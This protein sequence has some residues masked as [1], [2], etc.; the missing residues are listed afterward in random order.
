MNT[1]DLTSLHWS[2]LFF[3]NLE[4]YS[5]F[6]VFLNW[7]LWN[8]YI[9]MTRVFQFWFFFL[10]WKSAVFYFPKSRPWFSMYIHELVLSS[11]FVI[12]VWSPVVCLC[13]LSPLLLYGFK[14]LEGGAM[15]MFKQRF[16]N[17]ITLTFFSGQWSMGHCFY[18]FRNL[19]GLIYFIVL[20][21][22]IS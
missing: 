14:F 13:L 5:Y 19:M 15:Y 6:L 1:A 20:S 4:K 21:L 2:A 7:V 17:Q 16:W 12:F 10:T 22:I 3:N 9:T 18:L 8:I 11:L